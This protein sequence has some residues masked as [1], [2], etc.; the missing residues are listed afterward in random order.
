MTT[1]EDFQD[2]MGPLNITIKMNLE[3]Y[4]NLFTNNTSY[5]GYV[6]ETLMILQRIV[7]REEDFLGQRDRWQHSE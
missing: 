2:F 4:C 3:T 6:T 5:L 1:I 7:K